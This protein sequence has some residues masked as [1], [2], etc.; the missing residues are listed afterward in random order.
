MS[1]L[2]LE[3]PIA[4]KPRDDDPEALPGKTGSKNREERIL[5]DSKSVSCPD[6]RGMNATGTYAAKGP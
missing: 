2:R 1:D 4:E 6:A 5:L 3:L